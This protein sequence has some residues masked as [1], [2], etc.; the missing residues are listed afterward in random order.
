MIIKILIISLLIYGNIGLLN[1]CIPDIHE[2]MMAMKQPAV[3]SMPTVYNLT[4]TM[5]NAVIGQCDADPLITAGMYKI[6][7]SNASEHRWIALSRNLL[8]RWGGKFWYGDIVIIS[9]AGHKD[10]TYKIVDTMNKRFKNRI[11]FLETTGTD[12]YKFNNITMEKV[13]V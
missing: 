8:K 1:T 3:K 6:N 5:Y 7:Y 2:P 10:G 11:D 9:N 4:G 12:R 13:E